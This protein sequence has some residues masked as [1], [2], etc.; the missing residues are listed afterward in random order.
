MIACLS[1]ERFSSSSSFY[2][3]LLFYFHIFFIIIIIL[4]REGLSPPKFAFVVCVCIFCFMFVC[5]LICRFLWSEGYI[6]R[7]VLKGAFADHADRV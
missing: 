3:M 5:G 2:F 4:T 7:R 6:M 1:V